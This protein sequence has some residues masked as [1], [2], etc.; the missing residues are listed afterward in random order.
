MHKKSRRFVRAAIAFSVCPLPVRKI[1]NCII[2]LDYSVEAFFL[3]GGK[4]TSY[5]L[6]SFLPTP[7]ASYLVGSFLPTPSLPAREF[8]NQVSLPF[9]Q[10]L[11]FYF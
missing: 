3:G 9:L 11:H 2:H 7:M 5:P 4:V 1:I 6:G 8:L 10:I